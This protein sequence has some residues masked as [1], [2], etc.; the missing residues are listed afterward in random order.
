[1]ASNER[2][3]LYE[4]EAIQKFILTKENLLKGWGIFSFTKWV[5]FISSIMISD[6][7][8]IY[9]LWLA[10]N[11]V[12]EV[13]QLVMNVYYRY[14]NDNKKFSYLRAFI[15]HFDAFNL[16]DSGIIALLAHK[17]YYYYFRRGEDED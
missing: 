11:T 13:N 9:I 4:I 5:C 10:V 15:N 1:M 16:I 14:K 8:V 17:V 6:K 7:I 2:P 3:N 12:L